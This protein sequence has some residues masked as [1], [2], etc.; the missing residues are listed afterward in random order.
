MSLHRR[1]LSLRHRRQ[2]PLLPRP[3]EVPLPS[4]PELQAEQTEWTPLI[5]VE[6]RYVMDAI[7]SMN[8]HRGRPCSNSSSIPLS[9]SFTGNS[10]HSSRRQCRFSFHTCS[11]STNCSSIS[12]TTGSPMMRISELPLQE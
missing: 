1:L 8:S 3:K 2:P 4:D 10:S 6:L 5:E 9:S 11:S 7:F 12:S